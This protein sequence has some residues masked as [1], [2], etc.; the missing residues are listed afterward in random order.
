[1]EDYI[2][3]LKN[4]FNQRI[5]V[6]EKRP[7][8]IQLFAPLYHEDGDMIDIY[9]EQPNGNG[10]IRISDHGMTL[11]RLSY[12]YEI[13]TPNKERIF[14]RILAENRLLFKNGRIYLDALPESLYPSILQFAQG[15]AKVSNMRLFKREVIKS[16]FYEILDEIVLD[17]FKKF[18]VRPKVLPIKVR[19]DLEVDYEISPN[20]KPFYLF[21]VKDDYKARLVVISCLEFQ[22]NRLPFTSVIIHED[23]DALTRKDRKRITSAADKQFTDLDDFKEN[24]LGYIEREAA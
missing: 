8:I 15:V 11:M 14:N 20:K 24:G 12:N 23:F 16:L 19:D 5:N 9:L 6:Q 13:D 3:L 17:Q 4:Q 22:R 18:H 21:G 2:G 1:M 7:G 10:T